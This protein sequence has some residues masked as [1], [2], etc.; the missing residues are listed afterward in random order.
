MR[1]PRD[2]SPRIVTS[3]TAGAAF[4]GASLMASAA[5]V[6]DAPAV[7]HSSSSFTSSAD[8]GRLPSGGMN[9]SSLAGKVTRWKS[10]L[11]LGISSFDNRAALAPSH[12]AFVSIQPQMRFSFG[13]SVAG[14]AVCCEH[15]L[16]AHR[17]ER[18]AGRCRRTFVFGRKP[19]PIAQL[20]RHVFS[21]MIF[22]LRELAAAI[23]RPGHQADGDYQTK[24]INQIQTLAGEAPAQHPA[25]PAKSRNEYSAPHVLR[26]QR[27]RISTATRQAPSEDCR[28]DSAEGSQRQYEINRGAQLGKVT[29]LPSQL[30]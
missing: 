20:I 9:L 3:A 21:E 16:Q 4:V 23:T 24:G 12:H 6:G 29:V 28:G 13:R 2:Q 11:P 14:G 7:I 8:R 5:S 19:Q 22:A 26:D 25:Q 10:S 17:K 18:S 1:Q 30:Q 27:P 15:G